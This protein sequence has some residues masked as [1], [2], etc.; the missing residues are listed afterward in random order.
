MRDRQFLLENLS[1][2]TDMTIYIFDRD[3]NMEFGIRSGRAAT[4]SFIYDSLVQS[5]C[6]SVCFESNTVILV[7]EKNKIIYGCMELF[8]GSVFILGPCALHKLT[9]TEITEYKQQHGIDE[10]EYDIPVFSHEKIQGCMRVAASLMT[11]ECVEGRILEVSYK[12]L[13]VQKG[14]ESEL[15]DYRLDNSESER[16]RFSFD[17][18]ERWIRC[19]ENGILPEYAGH[20][21]MNALQEK[22][23]RLADGKDKQMEYLFVCAD[24]LATRAAIRGGVSAFEAYE[25]SDIY[26]QKLEKCTS[27]SAVIKLT[28]TM[29]ED[30]VRRVRG[31]KE[32]N[33]KSQYVEKCKDYIAQHINQKLSVNEMANE[34][35]FNRSYISQRFKAEEGISIQEYIMKE[36]VRMA[37]NMLKYSDATI[38]RIA[39]YL[40][41]SSQSHMGI[42]FKKYT[43]FSPKEYRMRYQIKDFV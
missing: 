16:V 33:K 29:I 24:T 5:I 26:L 34:I 15:L 21:D 22:I 38:S 6:G 19:I 12:E 37:E 25:L 7:T 36:R 28:N 20:E 17:Y 41:F 9:E 14:I 4:D 40:G 10:S 39:E 42:H 23:G 32:E 43:G 31:K 11:G 30:F 8:D 18:E 3:G 35:G 1:L 13:D 27:S 2:C